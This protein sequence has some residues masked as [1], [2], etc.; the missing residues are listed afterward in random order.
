MY[1][2]G[3][4]QINN[5]VQCG[6]YRQKE[7]YFNTYNHQTPQNR[8]DKELT[9]AYSKEWKTDNV[10]T[11]SLT[12]STSTGV[13][14]GDFVWV[15]KYNE[16]S[17]QTEVILEPADTA[18]HP[19]W[20][21]KINAP[22]AFQNQTV[23]LHASSNAVGD[24]NVV[25]VVMLPR[26]SCFEAKIDPL[27]VNRLIKMC[28]ALTN[29]DVG[30]DP[31]MMS[32]RIAAVGAAVLKRTSTQLQRM[33]T[34]VEESV[35]TDTTQIL[36]WCSL[37]IWYAAQFS[38]AV[39]LQGPVRASIR[40][41]DV[42]ICSPD[43]LAELPFV[44]SSSHSHGQARTDHSFAFVAHCGH[45]VS[46]LLFQNQSQDVALPDCIDTVFSK[47]SVLLTI[48]DSPGNFIRRAPSTQRRSSQQN[49]NWVSYRCRSH[50]DQGHIL[51]SD[52]TICFL[53]TRECSAVCS[54]HQTTGHSTLH[55]H[56]P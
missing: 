12:A 5:T 37:R 3:S 34:N 24:D 25:S 49:Q 7:H 28:N 1:S 45:S 26:G 32:S 22:V 41:G 51:G 44:G 35:K 20:I 30:P 11:F 9:H 54:I 2:P 18:K 4:I 52:A 17:D 14:L 55:L 16:F 43:I 39:T 40:D 31:L 50:A 21:L 47:W 15:D 23:M 13:Y 10:S 46:L 33:K 6:L 53:F 48:A 56:S 19:D 38:A 8:Y 29:I 36:C 42:A 27:V